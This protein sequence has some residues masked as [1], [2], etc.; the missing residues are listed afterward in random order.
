M[1]VCSELL[2][3]GGAGSGAGAAGAAESTSRCLLVLED[4]VQESLSTLRAGAAVVPGTMGSGHGGASALQ[5]A[6]RQDMA[7]VMQQRQA[8]AVPCCVAHAG[9]RTTEREP[10]PDRNSELT[11]IYLR[12]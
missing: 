6:Y 2:C 8:S 5:E 1:V 10:G 11:A 12:F 7:S 3:P 4:A 9:A